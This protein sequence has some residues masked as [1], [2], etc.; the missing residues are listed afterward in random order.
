MTVEEAEHASATRLY[1]NTARVHFDAHAMKDSTAGRRLVYGGHIISLARAMSFNGLENALQVLGWNSGVHA[2]PTFAGDT[3]YAFSEVL[4][5]T[6][7]PNREEFDALRLRLVAV[8][9]YD[10]ASGEFGIQVDDESGGRTAYHP[11]VVLDLD[12]Y[13]LMPNVRVPAAKSSAH[14]SST[15]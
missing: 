14:A 13:V 15:G 7:L 5:R 8:K 10:P 6:P 12:Y 3:L 9:N 1:Q 2:N 11:N 4:G